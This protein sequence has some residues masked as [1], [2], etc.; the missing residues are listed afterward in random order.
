MEII[1]TSAGKKRLARNGFVYT[2]KKTSKS[3]IRWEC[4]QRAAKSCKGAVVADI[5]M[6]TINSTKSHNHEGDQF[7]VEALKLREDKRNKECLGKP[8]SASVIF[9]MMKKKKHDFDVL[10]ALAG[11]QFDILYIY[12]LL[13]IHTK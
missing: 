7:H 5:N 4:S 3:T 11:A 12:T 2:K 9:A 10:N 6:T 13:V 1:T 8:V